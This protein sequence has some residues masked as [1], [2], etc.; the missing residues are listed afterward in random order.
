MSDK[1]DVTALVLAGGEA[2]RMGGV[3]KGLQLYAG[4]TLIEIMMAL[5]KPVSQQQ[6]I[7][8]NRSLVVYQTLSNTVVTDVAPWQG[9]GPLGGL[10]A[11]LDRLTTSHLLLLPCDTPR[12]SAEA[13][14]CLLQA[15][16]QAPELIHFIETESGPQPLHAV[17]PVAALKQSL[18]I[19]LAQT[20][21]FGVMSF[22]KQIGRQA[23][24]WEHDEELVNINYL[25]QLA[26]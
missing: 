11:I 7:S 21:H 26:P 4:R 18:P 3:D 6:F 8:A 22:Y 9:I 19:F 25:D 13:L 15:A 10:F 23:V 1:F 16:E 14:K 24:Y 20:E 2:Q 17:L 5:V 12:F